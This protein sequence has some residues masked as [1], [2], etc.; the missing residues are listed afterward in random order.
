MKK[1]GSLLAVSID[2]SSKE[3][4]VDGIKIVNAQEV[5]W[6]NYLII[7]Q[8][9]ERSALGSEELGNAVCGISNDVLDKLSPW[10]R[11]GQELAVS[12]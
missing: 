8:S 12:R 6:S 2:S 5:G 9:D 4:S 7:D 3:P 1:F 11:V 10:L